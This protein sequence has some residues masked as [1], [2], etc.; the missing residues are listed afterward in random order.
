[1]PGSVFAGCLWGV[2]ITVSLVAFLVAFWGCL[3]LIDKGEAQMQP[4]FDTTGDSAGE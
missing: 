3:W 4:S 2:L 1:M